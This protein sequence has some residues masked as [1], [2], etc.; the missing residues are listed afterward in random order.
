LVFLLAKQRE[1]S[2]PVHKSGGKDRQ[3][4]D[5]YGRE[6][7]ATKRGSGAVAEKY[8]IDAGFYTVVMCIIYLGWTQCRRPSRRAKSGAQLRKTAGFLILSH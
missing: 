7:Q 6:G 8:G 4:F 2:R 1:A 3:S 5:C